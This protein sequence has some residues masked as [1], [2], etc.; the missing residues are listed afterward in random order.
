MKGEQ[1]TRQAPGVRWRAAQ[2]RRDRNRH[3]VRSILLEGEAVAL[4]HDPVSP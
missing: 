4:I 2:T 1:I 3:S